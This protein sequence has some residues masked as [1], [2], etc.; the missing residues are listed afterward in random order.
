MGMAEI[1]QQ[2]ADAMHRLGLRIGLGDFGRDLA[3][4]A[5]LKLAPIDLVVLAPEAIHS[6]KGPV[7]ESTLAS[8][9][10]R[11]QD[12]NAQVVARD[13]ERKEALALVERLGVEYVLST[14]VAA[15]STEFQFEFKS[16]LRQR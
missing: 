4:V 6:S 15:P 9:V 16:W 3:A 13:I 1:R 14:A 5:R 7:E 8:L 2:V 10:R 11:A 12:G